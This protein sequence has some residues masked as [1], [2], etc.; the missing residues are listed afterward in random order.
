MGRTSLLSVRTNVRF[1]GVRPVTRVDRWRRGLYPVAGVQETGG[2]GTQPGA[3]TE[4]GLEYARRLYDRIIAWYESA[5]RKA[6]LILTLDGVFL[7]FLTASV[8]TKPGDLHLI[9]DRFGAETWALFGLMC[10]AL[11]L[12][13][14]SAVGCLVSRI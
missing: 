14:A 1:A 7:S 5:E 13:I 6:Q 11:F 3:G 10:V 2:G 4:A 8:L 9:V 12:S